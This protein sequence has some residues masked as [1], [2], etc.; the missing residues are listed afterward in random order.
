MAVRTRPPAEPVTR[1]TGR[2]SA[3]QKGSDGSSIPLCPGDRTPGV[4]RLRRPAGR[5]ST[6]RSPPGG[7]RSSWRRR[8][9]SAPAR[10]RLRGHRVSGGGP[11]PRW[12][13]ARGGPRRPP[14]R[15]AVVR[16]PVRDGRPA[17]V[18]RVDVGGELAVE[19]RTE[20][21]VAHP[22]DPGLPDR[23][24]MRGPRTPGGPST[25]GPSPAPW[26]PRV[27]AV[28]RA[29]RGPWPR[30][31]SRRGRRRKEAAPADARTWIPSWATRTR[32]TSPVTRSAATLPTRRSS[33][34]SASVT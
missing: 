12:C 6:R 13:G 20:P 2:V 4:S 18:A 26:S 33:R 30:A 32:V 22:H 3:A 28:P 19:G 1:A 8:S 5:W 10:L 23:W 11:R 9:P 27:R 24:S 31:P 14:C 34:R 7:G 15:L 16:A 25:L 29:P 17:H 21:V